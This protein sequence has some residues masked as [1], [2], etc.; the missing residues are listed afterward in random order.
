MT[1]A[2]R[3]LTTGVAG[4]VG[5]AVGM[6]LLLAAGLVAVQAPALSPPAAP[7][8][9]DVTLEITNAY[10]STLLQQQ[11]GDKPIELRD[12]QGGLQ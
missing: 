4:V 1:G 7:Q 12:P 5:L 6:L 2:V 10:M 3:W 11:G 9:W 8:E